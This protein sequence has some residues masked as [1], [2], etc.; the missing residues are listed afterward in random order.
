M[1]ALILYTF[2]LAMRETFFLLT[3]KS[4]KYEIHCHEIL[5]QDQQIIVQISITYI[6]YIHVF[7]QPLIFFKT[8]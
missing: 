8:R 3:T 7:I 1:L 2:F 6:L 5:S 4:L